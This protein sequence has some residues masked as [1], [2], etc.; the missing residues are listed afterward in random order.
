MHFDIDFEQTTPFNHFWRS[1]GYSP[2]EL[3]LTPDM[4][5][6]L[7]WAGSVPHQGILYNRV[8]F[9]LELVEV[10]INADDEPSYRW[11]LL[12]KA[13]DVILKNGARP[14]FELMGNPSEYFNNFNDDRQLHQWKEMISS[15][16]RHLIQRYGLD[17][18]LGWYFETWNEPD[19]SGWWVQW[20]ADETAFCRYYDACS[21][22]LWAVE[23]RL[24]MGGPGTCRHLS[25]LLKAFLEHVDRGTNVFSGE[26]GSRIDF[27]SVHEKGVRSHLEDLTPN[28]QGIA[29]REVEIVDYIRSHH[30]RLAGLPFMN[31]ECDPQV[32]WWHAHTWHG[33]P[34]Y[35]A[36]A[37]KIIHQ[38]L[39]TLLDGLQVNY[40]L[41][42][43]DN[44]FVGSWGNRTLV[45]RFG[46]DAFTDTGQSH[47]KPQAIREL[48]RNGR[49]PF[50]MVK[51]PIVNAFALLSMLGEGRA[52]VRGGSGEIGALATLN[53]QGQAALLIYHSRDKITSSGQERITLSLGGLPFERA[54]LAH[55]RIDEAHGNP[56]LLWET[57]GAP[58]RPSPDL[59]A[60]MRRAQ[61][62]ILLE[63]PQEVELQHG[64]FHLSFD[65]PLPGISLVLLTARPSG[66]PGKIEKVWVERYQG[67]HGWEDFV[68][69]QG[70]DSCGLRSYEVL[71]SVSAEG[72]YRRIN[73]ADLLCTGYLHTP[74]GT[75]PVFYR[76]RA[77]DYWGRSGPDSD[78]FRI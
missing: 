6:S 25:P 57:A 59:L 3:I 30:P 66:A 77:V 53:V 68:R 78:V 64:S 60:E 43:N 73:P 70:L 7:A 41:L 50:S 54:V 69:W 46:S 71:A 58:D 10:E 67:L 8:H 32:G 44:G 75:D 45:T 21:A 24:V 65:L 16:A 18:V 14:F 9:L 48:R 52:R 20:P 35:A 2:A 15:L 27:I 40:T 26:R 55:Y 28:S 38:H 22:G 17:E 31:N 63:E 74:G 76:V 61:E 39:Q 62:E 11:N 47:H 72:P 42:S 56:Y 37:A 51:K 29:D 36:I 23:P 33:T 19:G 1:T 4:Q 49:P 5:Q 12:D 13:L 34:Y